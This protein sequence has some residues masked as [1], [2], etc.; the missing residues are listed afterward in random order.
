MLRITEWE[1]IASF[2]LNCN[3]AFKDGWE[4]R[5]NHVVP[6]LGHESKGWGGY[7]YSNKNG[8]TIPDWFSRFYPIS[9]EEYL[10]Y[11]KELEEEYQI[12]LKKYKEKKQRK[13]HR[14]YFWLIVGATL[15]STLMVYQIMSFF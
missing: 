5:D 4:V 9:D 12:N 11:V 10:K 3:K 6:P 15:I 1:T 7:W 14:E 13:Q 2:N 8:I